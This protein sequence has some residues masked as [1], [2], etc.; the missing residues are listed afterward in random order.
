VAQKPEGKRSI[1]R[2]R[3]RWEYNIKMYLKEIKKMSMWN[4]FI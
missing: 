4:G 3:R 2:P 1:T